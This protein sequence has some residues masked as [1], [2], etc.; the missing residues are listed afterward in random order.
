MTDGGQKRERA[1]GAHARIL[2]TCNLIYMLRR[3]KSR[4]AISTA[5]LWTSPPLHLQ[6]IN[7]LV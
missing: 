7:V 5:R 2:S 6:P 3:G 4:R 1:R